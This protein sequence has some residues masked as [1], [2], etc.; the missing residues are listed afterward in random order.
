MAELATIS[1]PRTLAVDIGGTN[2]K[3]LVLDDDGNAISE[4]VKLPTP[5]PAVPAR[6][7]DLIAQ[8][9][10][11]QPEFQRISVGFPGVVHHGIT[12]TAPNLH[13]D[14]HGFP[15]QQVLEDRLGCPVRVCNDADV[16]G[17]GAIQ[18]EGLEMVI[19]LGTGMGSALFVDGILVPNLELAHHPFGD[20]KTYEQWLGNASLAAIGEAAWEAKLREAIELMRRIFNYDRLYIGGGNVRLLERGDIPDDVILIDNIAGLLGGIALWTGVHGTRLVRAP[21]SIGAY[22]VVP[23]PAR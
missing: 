2:I 9:A 4:R 22:C 16:Q 10:D 8:L 17:F 1:G 5:K 23:P 13:P 15:C 20:G 6:V 19:T 12:A 18:G 11:G 21:H 14:W 7:I 3:V